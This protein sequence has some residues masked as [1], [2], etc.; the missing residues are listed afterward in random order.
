MLL[1]R[2]TG[3]KFTSLAKLSSLFRPFSIRFSLLSKISPFFRKWR[4]AAFS[5]FTIDSVG[6][7]VFAF[8]QDFHFHF[9]YLGSSCSV[10]F[11]YRCRV[12]YQIL[13]QF[14]KQTSLGRLSRVAHI[15]VQ[16]SIMVREFCFTFQSYLRCIL[17][18]LQF[19]HYVFRFFLFSCILISN[20]IIN[21]ITTLC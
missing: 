12:E 19:N 5:S 2:A 14:L 9:G 3:S 1:P 10:F 17:V 13:N 6:I 20:S 21:N 11:L 18:W 4:F 8:F 16:S 7:C 15:R